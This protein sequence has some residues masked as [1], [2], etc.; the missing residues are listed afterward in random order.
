MKHTNLFIR[1]KTSIIERLAE[2]KRSKTIK[3]LT[4]RPFYLFSL[5][6]MDHHATQSEPERK[7]R[8]RVTDPGG[9]NRA[10]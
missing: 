9:L 5:V 8:S 3:P 1:F 4:F 2:I 10:K 7:P 6:I